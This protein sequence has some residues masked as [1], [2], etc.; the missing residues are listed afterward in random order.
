MNSITQRVHLA[1][2][3]RFIGWTCELSGRGGTISS[4]LVSG[5]KN[6]GLHMIVGLGS[7]QKAVPADQRIALWRPADK[8]AHLHCGLSCRTLHANKDVVVSAA[9]MKDYLGYLAFVDGGAGPG[10]HL[11]L[12]ADTEGEVVNLTVS[13]S[14]LVGTID[15]M[16]KVSPPT[17]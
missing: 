3:A 7:I 13:S 16:I 1:D 11:V 17:K 5:V 4:H 2:L 14:E 8:I 12:A 6:T 15:I 10:P 9:E